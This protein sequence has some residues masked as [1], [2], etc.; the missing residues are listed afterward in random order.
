M[1]ESVYTRVAGIAPVC[2][3]AFHANLATHVR[4]TVPVQRNQSL[5]SGKAN[6]VGSRWVV[7]K[8]RTHNIGFIAIKRTRCAKNDV[9]MMWPYA[10]TLDINSSGFPS[11]MRDAC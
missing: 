6:T 8:R 11:V 2:C 3:R 4:F 1:L 10:A 9:H 5:R 7:Y